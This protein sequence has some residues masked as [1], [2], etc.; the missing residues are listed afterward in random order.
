MRLRLF[1][2][3]LLFSATGVQAGTIRIQSRVDTTLTGQSL[4]VDIAVTNQGTESARNVQI[5]SEFET[6]KKSSPVQAELPVQGNMATHLRQEIP[7]GMHGRYPLITRILYTDSNGYPFSVL[8]VSVVNTT[9]T[10][11]PPQV[12]GEL[13]PLLIRD[14]GRLL[15]TVTNRETGQE[16]IRIHLIYSREFSADPSLMDVEIAPSEVKSFSITLHNNSALPGSTY[17]LYAIME[18]DQ[19]RFHQ[20]AMVTGSVTIVPT[21]YTAPMSGTPWLYFAT[22]TLLILIVVVYNVRA[23]RRRS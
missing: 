2:M 13:Q 23:F 5:E 4:K 8:V 20:T 6:S 7:Y 1:L 19:N 14:L 22:L 18:Y 17:P 10:R 16:K 11:T 15:L 3:G 12:I 21:N 9:T